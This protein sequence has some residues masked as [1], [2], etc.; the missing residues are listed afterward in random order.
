MFPLHSFGTLRNENP[1]LLVRTLA[2][3]LLPATTATARLIRAAER[4][5]VTSWT[6]ARTLQAGSATRHSWDYKNPQGV[7]FMT[8]SARNT[9]DQGTHGNQLAA[10]LD[11]YLVEAPHAGD[12]VEDHWRLGLLRIGRHGFEAKCFHGEGCV[13]A[14]CAGEYFALEGHP[15]IDTHPPAEREF[16]IVQL[17]VAARNNL[18]KDLNVHAEQLFAGWQ[19]LRNEL[20][21]T[22]QNTD[23]GGNNGLMQV[24]FT[25]VRASLPWP[26][27]LR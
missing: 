20:L 11:D 22:E 13:R 17:E 19:H 15:E 9:A 4:D 2:Q 14:F 21:P 3:V 23:D 16:I 24:R 1:R 26:P 7:Q 25:T 5:V 8:T 12:N 10:T 27:C 18:P 6:A